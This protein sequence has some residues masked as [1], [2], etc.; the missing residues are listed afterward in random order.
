VVVIPFNE[1][2][3]IEYLFLREFGV[4]R[5]E[6][7]DFPYVKVLYFIEKLKQEHRDLEREMKKV[8]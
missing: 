3:E 5:K 2:W 6:L 8:R 4:H 1:D 7:N